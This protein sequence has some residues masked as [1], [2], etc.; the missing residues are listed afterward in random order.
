MTATVE[1][2]VSEVCDRLGVDELFIRRL[3]DG[4]VVQPSGGGG[5][6]R[7][8]HRRWHLAD[9]GVLS[10]CQQLHAAG[11]SPEL[12]CRAVR[13]LHN[14]DKV[15]FG[16]VLVVGVGYGPRLLGDHGLLHL[17][18]S[19]KEAVLVVSLHGEIRRWLNQRP[20][21]VEW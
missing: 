18:Q 17:V 11:A 15:P 4:G 19:A 14:V 10:V 7:G 6:Q 9:L 3:V 13:Y 21:T 12:M 5:G 8:Q 20:E 1:L 2:S 16:M